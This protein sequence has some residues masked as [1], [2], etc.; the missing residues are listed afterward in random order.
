MKYGGK[1]KAKLQMED[2]SVGEV[3]FIDEKRGFFAIFD[4]HVD[5]NAAV[6][7]KSI[8][9][10]EF[11]KQIRKLKNEY[12][13]VAE[14][15][16]HSFYQVDSQLSEYDFEGATATVAFVW[17]AGEDRYLQV[18]NVGD[19]TAFLCRNGT[20]ELLSRDHKVT[21]ADE[22]ARL[23]Q[24]GFPYSEGQTR[25]NGLAVSRAL[26][27]HFLKQNNLGVIVEPF[28]SVPYKLTPTDS[29]I[30]LASDGLW[31]VM[32]GQEAVDMIKDI[33][34][35]DK[36]ARKLVISALHSPKCTDNVTVIV[37]TL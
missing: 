1:A 9:P 23:K 7:A 6:K 24:G 31:D 36:M 2:M 12:K 29:F 3:P 28:I 21:G 26:G 33:E 17:K 5:K 20:A 34:A 8:F 37:I 19:S 15:F 10:R 35:P 25:I 18:A 4:G 27:D 16:R 32:S 22:I 14:V 13:D 30:V 11:E